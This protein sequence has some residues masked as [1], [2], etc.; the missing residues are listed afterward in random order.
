[1]GEQ[2]AEGSFLN[3]NQ[4]RAVAQI[5]CPQ[6]KLLIELNAKLNGTYLWFG[7][8]KTKLELTRNQADQDDN[9]SRV[10]SSS[11][12]ERFSFKCSDGY[13]NRGRDLI[14]TCK[15]DTEN[16]VDYFATMAKL[17]NKQLPKVMQS[18][19][20]DEQK[21]Y[22]KKM[23]DERTKLQEQIAEVS[24]QRVEHEKLERAKLA[25]QSEED[26][27]ADAIAV[28]VKK[29]LTTSGFSTGE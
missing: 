21:T 28:A 5:K 26:T 25:D 18:M 1:M 29:Q 15:S 23:A 9:Y 19:S 10:G 13:S 16:G 2:V 11:L 3:I 20:L 12:S 17:E 7:S 6:D 22:V 27:L 14:D 4:D 8:D 24:V